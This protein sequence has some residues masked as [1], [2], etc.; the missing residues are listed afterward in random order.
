MKAY[1]SILAYNHVNSS[2]IGGQ[3][4]FNQYIRDFFEDNKHLKREDAIKCWNYKKNLRR[5]H[6]YEKSDLEIL[7]K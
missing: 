3:F 7:N 1:Y 6:K 2:E 4:E 5:I